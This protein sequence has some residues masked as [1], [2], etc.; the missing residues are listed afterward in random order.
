MS[1]GN[2]VHYFQHF[3]KMLARQKIVPL[4]T[5]ALSRYI[6]IFHS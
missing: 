1:E 5:V 6:E 4:R 3:M 2:H